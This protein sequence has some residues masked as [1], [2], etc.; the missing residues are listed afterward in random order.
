M[1]MCQ[2][3]FSWP[4]IIEAG[5][6]TSSKKTSLN[7]ATPVISTSGRIVMPGVFMSRRRNVSPLCLGAFGSVRTSRMHQ[8]A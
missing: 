1:A 7:Q 5:I 6:C 3:S 2:P 4:I 8:S